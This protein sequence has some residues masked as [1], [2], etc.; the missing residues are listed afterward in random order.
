M[1]DISWLTDEDD[2]SAEDAADDAQSGDFEA[3]PPG[4]YEVE[5]ISAEEREIDND[6]ATGLGVNVQFAV[7]GDKY[8][9]R[10]LFEWFNVLYR[11]KSSDD[12]AKEKAAKIQRIGRGQFGALCVALGIPKRPGSYDELVGKFALAKVGKRTREWRGEEREENYVKSFKSSQEYTNASRP[13]AAGSS[14]WS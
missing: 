14:P 12:D 2:W 3:I 4:E 6:K 10:R 9:N 1:G 13:K 8:D 7:R 5:V 11:P